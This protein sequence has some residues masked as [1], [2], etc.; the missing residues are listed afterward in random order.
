[1]SKTA[2]EIG[3]LLRGE[4]EQLGFTLDQAATAL[5]IRAKYLRAIEDG[6]ITEIPSVVYLIGYLKNYADFL[7]L[8]GDE[9][10][11]AFKAE[12][13]HTISYPEL[14]LPEPYRK[15]FHPRPIALLVSIVLTLLGYSV[16][17]YHQDR[18][19]TEP[20]TTSE[21][22]T[23]SPVVLA[24]PATEGTN[25]ASHRGEIQTVNPSIVLLAKTNTWIRVMDSNSRLLSERILHPGDTYFVSKEEGQV[26]TSD[27]PQALDV[28][29]NGQLSSLNAV[30]MQQ[31]ASSGK[32]VGSR[33]LDATNR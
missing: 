11:D 2:I 7:E 23:T 33:F 17:Y 20:I 19:D 24:Q 18:E 1:M 14:Y 12:G 21:I 5:K 4:R 32:I 16:W 15:D 30:N 28:M 22:E 25:I 13:D 3:G 31:T 6:N 29:Y 9:L 10:I 26:I 27:N 8:N